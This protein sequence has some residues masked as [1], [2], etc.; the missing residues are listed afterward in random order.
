ML[1]FKKYIYL[2]NDLTNAILSKE[3]VDLEARNK[4]LKIILIIA[5]ISLILSL[6][7]NLYLLIYFS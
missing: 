3:R 4:K 6:L 7:L 1:K 5:S 2:L